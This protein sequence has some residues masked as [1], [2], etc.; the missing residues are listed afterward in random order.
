[1]FTQLTAESS[2]KVGAV[3][4]FLLLLFLA[5]SVIVFEIHLFHGQSALHYL[6]FKFSYSRDLHFNAQVSNNPW[7]WPIILFGTEVNKTVNCRRQFSQWH[8]PESQTNL[9]VITNFIL[10]TRKKFLPVSWNVVSQFGFLGISVG[11]FV[12]RYHKLYGYNKIQKNT[13]KWKGFRDGLSHSILQRAKKQAITQPWSQ[14]VEFM[15]PRLGNVNFP[16]FLCFS[17]G[18]S[19][20]L[21]GSLPCF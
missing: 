8:D 17:E 2:R 11:N 16:L 13:W 6:V 7:L 4:S 20:T 18:W 19:M 3:L 1:M 10:V 12:T 15:G 14:Y 9:Y 21:F 5:C